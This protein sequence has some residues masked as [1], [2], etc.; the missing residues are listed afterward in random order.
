MKGGLLMV[1]AQTKKEIDKLVKDIRQL[2]PISMAMVSASVHTLL[3]KQEMD[4][5]AK[6][7]EKIA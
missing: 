2:S 1:K 4:N 3:A 7:P 6:P 5:H